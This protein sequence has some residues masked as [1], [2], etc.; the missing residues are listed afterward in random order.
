MYDIPV[1][2]SMQ[3]FFTFDTSSPADLHPP[4]A[5]HF[6]NTT[7]TKEVNLKKPLRS[8]NYYYCYYIIDVSFMQGIYTYIPETKPCP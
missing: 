8:Y 6:Q 1:L 3:Y 5:P 7:H 2:D 4:S